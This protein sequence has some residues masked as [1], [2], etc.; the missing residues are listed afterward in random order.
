M[1]WKSYHEKLLNTEFTWD[2]NSLSQADT[3]SDIPCLSEKDMVRESVSTTKKKKAT[4]SSG[5]NI[6]VSNIV[7][8]PGETEFDMITDLSKSDYCRRSYLGRMET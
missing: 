1:A 3:V 7:K 2:R 6:V 8:T 5:V 4:G